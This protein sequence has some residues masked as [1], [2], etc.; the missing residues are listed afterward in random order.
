MELIQE[1]EGRVHFVSKYNIFLGRYSELYG[2]MALL[3]GVD[4]PE[5]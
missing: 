1:G 4:T 5:R 3:G 2:C